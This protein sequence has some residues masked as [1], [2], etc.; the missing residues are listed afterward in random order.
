MS[1]KTIISFFSILFFTLKKNLISIQ[2]KHQLKIHSQF[3][4]LY[5]KETFIFRV[6]IENQN[7]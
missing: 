5:S 4:A 2:E 3:N 6:V 1:L 7:Y